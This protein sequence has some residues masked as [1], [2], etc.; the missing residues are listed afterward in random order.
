MTYT[1][2]KRRADLII[3][4]LLLVAFSPI[5]LL[6]LLLLLLVQG[7]P[8]LYRQQRIGKH[9]QPFQLLKFR[10]MID[11]APPHIPDR[12]VAKLPD[13]PRITPLG[14]FIRRFAIDEIPQL[15]NVLRGEMSLVGPRPLPRE[16]LERHGWLEVADPAERSRRA[17]WLSQRQQVPPGLTGRWQITAQPEADFDNWITCDL[18]YVAHP[19]LRG[20]LLIILNTPFAVLRGRRQ[21]E[22]DA[23][24]STSQT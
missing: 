6:T 7:R 3:A 21:S 24:S 12:P 2:W 23:I 5:W 13:D 15:L 1:Y 14:R 4:T 16:D 9:G 18:A 10:T 11:G 8:L 20:D 22:T 19:T 17:D